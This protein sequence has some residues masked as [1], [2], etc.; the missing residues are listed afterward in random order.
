MGIVRIYSLDGSR[1]YIGGSNEGLIFIFTF[2]GV[3]Y[4]LN[5]LY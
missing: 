3:A 2:T 1:A 4:H 5:F